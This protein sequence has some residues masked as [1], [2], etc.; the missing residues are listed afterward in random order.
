MII[1]QSTRNAFFPYCLIIQRKGHFICEKKR[2]RF[3]LP[4]AVSLSSEWNLFTVFLLNTTQERTRI[5]EFRTT[6]LAVEVTGFQSTVGNPTK[7][8]LK[9]VKSSRCYV[10]YLKGLPFEGQNFPT[11]QSRIG[12]RVRGFCSFYGKLIGVLKIHKQYVVGIFS[13]QSGVGQQICGCT[14]SDT[15][16]GFQGPS[17][18]PPPINS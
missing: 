15:A 7:T 10:E 1:F 4:K 18:T 11:E 6:E 17:G 8:D 9:E 5:C 13:A 16:Q 2:K 14:L 12:H 3:D